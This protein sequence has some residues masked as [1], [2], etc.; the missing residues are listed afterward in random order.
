MEAAVGERCCKRC[1][2]RWLWTAEFWPTYKRN[3]ETRLLGTCR[4]CLRRKQRERAKTAA[5]RRKTRARRRRWRERN[6]GAEYEHTLKYNH[7]DKGRE[8]TRRYNNSEKGRAVKEAYLATPE[9]QASRQRALRKYRAKRKQAARLARAKLTAALPL[10][11]VRPFVLAMLQRVAVDLPESTRVERK[12][13]GIG[14]LADLT[15][16]S[17]KQLRRILNETVKMVE[18]DVCD[19]LQTHED[20]NL[21]ELVSRA[22]EWALLTGD[23]WPVGYHRRGG[24]TV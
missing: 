15:G 6:P 22:E 23:A 7:T 21:G 12:W 2:K 20:W 10:A 18:L 16:V 13:M 1:G 9:G 3:G 17:E 8:R 5:G 24:F 19:R 11:V 14:E 4:E